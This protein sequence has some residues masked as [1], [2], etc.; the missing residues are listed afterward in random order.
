MSEGFR[1][2]GR[3]VPRFDGPVKAAGEVK[4]LEDLEL[5]GCWVGGVV[6]SQTPRGRLKEVRKLPGFDETG[7][8][9][10]TAK[11]IPAKNYV[12]IVR[13][14]YPVLAEREINYTTQAI[15]LVAAPTQEA[16]DKALAL[17]E[18]SVD[19]LPPVFSI[20]ESERAKTVIWGNDNCIDSYF[21]ERGDLK[22]GFEE[23]EVIVSGDWETGL[24]E[25]MYL[26]TQAMAAWRTEDGGIELVGSLQCPF[27]VVGA[28]STMLGLPAEKTVV[29]QSA[30]GGAF[31]GKED[32]P[33]IIGCFTALLAWVTGKKIKMA[34][35]RSEDLL[36]TPKRHP[37]KSHYKMGLTKGGKITALDVVMNLDAGAYTTLTRV[38]LQRTHL[39]AAGVYSV[40]NV[41]IKSAAWATNTPPNGAFRG[42]GAPQAIFAMERT[43]DLAAARLEI[44][45][46]DLRLM[47][48]MKAGDKFPFGQTLQESDNAAAVLQKAAELSDYRRKRA[49]YSQERSRRC[50]QG[51]GIAV[52]MHGG[53]FTGSGE[54]DMG[55]T[56]RVTFDGEIFR[57]YTSSTEMGQGASTVLPMVA[58]EALG[59]ELADVKY[60]EPN[61][62]YTPNTGPTVASRTTMYAG[63]AVQDACC[64]LRALIADGRGPLAA[65]ELVSAAKQYLRSHGQ[66]EA[67]GYNLFSDGLEWDADKFE[68]DAYHGYAWIANVVELEVDM[69]TYE[70]SPLRTAIAAE[71]GRAINPMQAKAQLTGGVLQALGWA[72]IEELTIK[73]DGNFSSAHMNSYLVPTSMDA[74]EWKIALVED[75]CPAGCY[76]AK[77]IGELPCDAGAPAFIS[78]LD[79]A[80][81]IF[82]H[83]CPMT[84]EKIFEAEQAQTTGSVTDR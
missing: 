66:L 10:V 46:L 28:V 78:A 16:L 81:G 8:L 20:E 1:I 12:A 19:P 9:L 84:G 33:S 49:L 2:I 17:V 73:P 60:I 51:I 61:T 80:A 30:T 38:V 57:I 34:L 15:A 58:A 22:A 36:V 47:N 41:R 65:G 3:S 74:P 63:K 70:A 54:A 4:F 37:S 55:T 62:K 72:H 6:R 52:A 48:A 40:P 26:E 23:A 39:H 83:S 43:M 27:Y 11:D 18:A 31:G 59:V 77:G 71:V 69:D 56:A 29:R 68:G 76:G 75:P 13:T 25:Q 64:K 44:D 50:R 7:A 21:T 82:S 5:P 67:L 53:G 35:D 32:Y 42:F 14:D 45:P 24:Q 79:H